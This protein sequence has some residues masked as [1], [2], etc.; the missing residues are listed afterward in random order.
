[1]NLIQGDMSIDEYEKSFIKQAKYA[2]AFVLDE[3]DKCKR[4]GEG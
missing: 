3:A 4:F 1:M 2:L